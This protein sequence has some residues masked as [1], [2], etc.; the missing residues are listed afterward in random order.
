MPMSASS[1][2][3]VVALALS[4]AL[5]LAACATPRRAATTTVASVP[6]PVAPLPHTSVEV[7]EAEG[8][9]EGEADGAAE[10]VQEAKASPAP[11]QPYDTTRAGLAVAVPRGWKTKRRDMALIYEGPMRVPS[12]VFFEPKARTLDD[13][14]KGLAEELRA[15]LGA[16]RITKQPVAATV[17]G[18]PAYV[19]EGTGR[20]EGFAMRWRATIVEAE[21][22]TIMLGLTP[23]FLWGPNRGRVMAFERGVRRADVQTAGLDARETAAR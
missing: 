19:A 2:I 9:A 20:A 6:A 11:R 22:L 10:A 17:A 15:P 5:S 3:L 8:E 4:L 1:R 13:A 16:V 14:V 12:V 23:S 18:Y 7:A 21:T